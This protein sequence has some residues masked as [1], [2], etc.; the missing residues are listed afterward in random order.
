MY[1]YWKTSEISRGTPVLR[2]MIGMG[3]HKNGHFIWS[4]IDRENICI[5]SYTEFKY[6]II[7]DRKCK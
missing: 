1:I 3:C 7:I 5:F 4:P 6:V 2:I